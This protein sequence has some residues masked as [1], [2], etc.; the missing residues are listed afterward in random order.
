M[1]TTTP[2][3]TPKPK[4]AAKQ[5]TKRK[6]LKDTSI[7]PPLTTT[8]VVA[9]TDKQAKKTKTSSSDNEVPV[10]SKKMTAELPVDS[11]VASPTKTARASRSNSLNNSPSEPEKSAKKSKNIT[12]STTTQ[13]TTTTKLNIKT[14]ADTVTNK[15]PQTPKQSP[16]ALNLDSIKKEKKVPNLVESQVDPSTQT[17]NGTSLLI[18]IADAS[19][20]AVET[21]IE[22]IGVSNKS[23]DLN[24]NESEAAPKRKR[25]AELTD[26]Q[27]SNQINTPSSSYSSSSSTYSIK[28]P[29]N[30]KRQRKVTHLDMSNANSANSATTTNTTSRDV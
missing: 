8:P 15:Q 9:A 27:L 24:C 13:T 23:S 10:N 30:Q 19:A 1:P 6:S 16:H 25:S 3:S 12:P 14:E 26:E 11:S 20:L 5:V 4:P 18:Q 2:N 28:S 7:T 21:V 22:N 29:A 17:G